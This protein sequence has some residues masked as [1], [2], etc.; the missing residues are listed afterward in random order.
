MSNCCSQGSF[1]SEHNVFSGIPVRPGQEE[2]FREFT[3]MLDVSVHTITALVQDIR[4]LALWFTTA[5]QEPWDVGRVTVRDVADFREYLKSEKRQAVSTINRNLASIR[6]YFKYLTEVGHIEVNPTLGIKVLKKQQTAPQGLSRAEI[7]KLLR[8]VELRGDIRSKAVF[9]IILYT[10]CRLSDL[11]NLELSDIMLSERSGSCVFRNGKGNKQR[12]VPLPLQARK[13]VSDYL[14]VRPPVS[15]DKLFIGERGA[16]NSRGIQ[17]IFEKYRA[18][19]GIENLHCHV[20]RHSFS[21]TFLSQ[22]GN[23]VQLAQILGH[24]SLN[25]TAIYTKNTMEQLSCCRREVV[26]VYLGK[27]STSLC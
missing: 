14:E 19:T 11:V 17:S 10:G 26:V 12:S 27:L 4:K 23:L 9:S 21:H 15:T 18:I 16:L 1:N 5:N 20:L 13:A 3:E 24:E 22:N 8:E 6:K 25:T 7:R 2:H